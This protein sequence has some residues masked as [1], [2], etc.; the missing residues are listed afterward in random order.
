[1]TIYASQLTG[2]R[3]VR[4]LAFG[5]VQS[6]IQAS[7]FNAFSPFLNDYYWVLLDWELT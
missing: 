7:G 4:D 6:G 1:M 5:S 2:K 3:R